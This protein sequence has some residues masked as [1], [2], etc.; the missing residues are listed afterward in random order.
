MTD[1]PDPLA[2]AAA[3]ARRF[4]QSLPE[5]RVGPRRPVAALHRELGGPLPETG[6]N[7]AG[8]VEALASGVED[9]LAATAGPRYFGFVTG[10]ALP[11]ALAADWLTAAWDQNAVLFAA[12]PAAAVVE[13]IAAGWVLELLGLPATAGVGLVTGCQMANFTGLAAARHA[14]LA[15]AGWNVAEQGLRGAPPVAL[16]VG[17]EAHTTLVAALRMLGFGAAELTVIEADDQGR[18]RADT[19]AKAMEGGEG[20][21]IVCAQA[22]N[23]N[24][25]A[26]DPFG[27]VADLAAARGAW[28]HVD[29]AFGLWAAAA[30]AR[31][32]LVDGVARA[33]SWATD[34]HKWLNVPYDCGLAIVRDAEAQRAAMTSSAAYLERRDTDDRDPLDWVPEASRRARGFPLYA[35]L[36]SLGRA[37]VADLVDRC[38]RLAALMAEFVAADPAVEVLNDVVLNQVLV[39]FHPDPA[40]RAADAAEA[41][42]LTRAVVERVQQEGTCWLG[43]TVWHGVAA[44]RVSVSNWSTTDADVRRSAD[45]ILAAFN[46]VRSE[47]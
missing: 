6:H 34:A 29:G 41:D 12:S 1:Q 38:C 18:M 4:L 17:A 23:V 2:R 8:V 13:E 5:R 36:R 39:R 27:A 40:P 22:G 9:A 3:R 10:G 37:G 35:A 19:L 7:P 14:V 44:M 46:R 16:Y 28:L 32:H 21:A 31:R 25:G 24:T 43:G 26:F 33:D 42:A 45:S 47:Y 15:R 30:P 11:A 20:P